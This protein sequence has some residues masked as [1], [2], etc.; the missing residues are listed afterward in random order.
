M[1]NTFGTNIQY[2]LFG[3]SHG[4]AIGIIIDG[5]PAGITLDFELIHQQMNKRKAKGKISTPRHEADEIEIISGYFQNRT[6]GTPLTLLIKNT[7]TRS[8][9][10]ERTSFCVRPGHAD[11]S[12]HIKYHGCEDYRGG[13]HFS[14]RLTAPIV[15]AGAIAMQLLKQYKIQIGTHIASLHGIHDTSFSQYE[16]EIE[17]QIEMLHQHEFPTISSIKGQEMTSLIEETARQKN[18]VGG[19]LE[20]MVIHVPAGLGEPFFDS[21]ESILSHLLF[22]IPAVKGVEFGCG[23][24]FSKLYG[25]EAN[26]SFF[27]EENQIKTKTN[28]NGGINGG[29]T[30]GMPIHIKTVIKPTASIFQKQ[31]TVDV[32]KQESVSLELQ[33]RH[34]PAIIHR[35][36][37]VVDSMIAIGLLEVLTQMNATASFVK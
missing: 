6:T 28:H 1:K 14:G 30:N 19:I 36:A 9:D 18:S 22:S 5:L 27:I 34:D 8:Q 23:F 4:E 3:E 31:E 2:T 10:Y 35:A 15:A 37:V 26:D 7:N 29:I 32:L 24:A 11:Y 20:S 16:T 25:S 21:V 17:S 13:G 12:A 33:G